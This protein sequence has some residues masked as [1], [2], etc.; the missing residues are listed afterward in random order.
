MGKLKNLKIMLHEAVIDVIDELSIDAWDEVEDFVEN[1]KIELQ[2]DV[3]NHL[4]H[5]IEDHED[6]GL[7][8]MDDIDEI[9]EEEL[10]TDLNNTI[11]DYIYTNWGI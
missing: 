2:E 3:W 5:M 8:D 6:F 11:D 7:F 10:G 9:L 4:A 1:R